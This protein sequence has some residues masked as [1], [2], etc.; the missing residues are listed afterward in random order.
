MVAERLG[1][2]A[3][4]QGMELTGQNIAIEAVDIGFPEVRAPPPMASIRPCPSAKRQP[5]MT[6]YNGVSLAGPSRA[7]PWTKF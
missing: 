5:P 7:L 6:P 4:L 3:V 2:F 1:L